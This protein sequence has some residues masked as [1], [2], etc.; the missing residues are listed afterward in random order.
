GVVPEQADSVGGVETR[1]PHDAV[2]LPHAIG[3]LLAVLA[4]G[5]DD[6]HAVTDQ[7]ATLR[8]RQRGGDDG[9]WRLFQ[10]VAGHGVQHAAAKYRSIQGNGRAHSFAWRTM[11]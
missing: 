5:G 9:G 11:R 6:V 3:R 2:R 4:D 7:E 1:D 8:A 10:D